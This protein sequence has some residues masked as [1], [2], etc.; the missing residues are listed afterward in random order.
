M[1]TALLFQTF[2]NLLERIDIFFTMRFQAQYNIAI[3]L[4]KTAV[5]IPCKPF[6]T[7]FFCN[8]LNSKVI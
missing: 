1:N 2:Y 6:I 3:H 8:S 4:D 7:R 5:G